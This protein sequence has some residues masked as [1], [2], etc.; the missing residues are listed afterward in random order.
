MGD[1]YSGAA[2]PTNAGTYTLEIT[3]AE[4][5]NYQGGGATC[6]FTIEKAVVTVPA[7]EDKAYT[8]E[9][10]KAD[11]EDTEY[12]IVTKNDGGSEVAAY[13]VVLTLKDP[14]NYKWS[15]GT[16]TAD[17]TLEF[18]IVASGNSW[19]TPLSIVGIPQTSTRPYTR[20]K[21]ATTRL[22]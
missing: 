7:I 10:L 1:G 14:G 18:H 21:M 3:V 13:D 4:S 19:T 22:W 6:G 9:L 16:L 2:A 8:G 12:Y 11:V 20:R 17:I 15:D 5:A